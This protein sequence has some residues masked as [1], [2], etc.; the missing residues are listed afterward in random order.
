MPKPLK[1]LTPC[2]LEI[3]YLYT[4]KATIRFDKTALERVHVRVYSRDQ[5]TFYFG[6][7]VPTEDAREIYRGLL[8]RGACSNPEVVPV[9]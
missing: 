2:K 5:T 4:P 7:P 1:P 3:H 9:A 6:S 8:L